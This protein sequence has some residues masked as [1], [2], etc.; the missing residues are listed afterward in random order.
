MSKQVLDFVGLQRWQSSE[1][2]PYMR[3]STSTPT[4]HNTRTPSQ[5][6]LELEPRAQF[7]ASPP[8]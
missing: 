8:R 7:N 1:R 5:R 6:R 3:K 2:L 4:P